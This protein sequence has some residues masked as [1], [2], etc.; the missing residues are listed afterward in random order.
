MVFDEQFENFIQQMNHQHLEG[1]KFLVESLGSQRPVGGTGKGGD[2]A[3]LY[4]KA[5]SRVEV[6]TGEETKIKEWFSI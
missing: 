6:F 1:L 2:K 5:F 4:E 3:I